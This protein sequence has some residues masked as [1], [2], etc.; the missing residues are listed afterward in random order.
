[1]GHKS[2]RQ[3]YLVFCGFHASSIR[4]QGAAVQ[5]PSC[6]GPQREPRPLSSLH[7]STLLN[8]DPTHIT[9]LLL[10]FSLKLS[11]FFM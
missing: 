2:W 7:A 4:T 6:P 9:R 8:S 3:A 10:Y 1:M 11:W 5:T